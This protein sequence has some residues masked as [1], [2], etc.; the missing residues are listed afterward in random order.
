VVRI[1]SD[2][3]KTNGFNRVGY[4]LY[5]NTLVLSGQN[6]YRGATTL[7]RNTLRVGAPENPGT[8]GPLGKSPALNPGSIIFNG[9]VMSIELPQSVVLRIRDTDPP[10]KGATAQAQTKPA[11]LETGLVMF[12]QAL[13]SPGVIGGIDR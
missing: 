5:T 13:Q 12:P 2:G 6:T 1:I 7:S 3:G 10:M 11:T 8:S 4:P 9:S